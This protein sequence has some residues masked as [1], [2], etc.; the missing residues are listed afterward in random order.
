MSDQAICGQTST[1]DLLCRWV[2]SRRPFQR[3]RRE[4]VL[5]L[6]SVGSGFQQFGIRADYHHRSFVWAFL[7][8]RLLDPCKYLGTVACTPRR[9]KLAVASHGH[10]KRLSLVPH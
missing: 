10:R 4:L 9:V 7:D 5:N 2:Q 8:T 6:I 1:I 3:L